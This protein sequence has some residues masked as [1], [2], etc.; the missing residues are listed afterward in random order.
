MK[1]ENKLNFN[2]LMDKQVSNTNRKSVDFDNKN[3]NETKINKNINK[4][5]IN[6]NK[7]I[8][9][10]M[11]IIS[12]K[13][14]S[15]TPIIN[16]NV[17]LVSQVNDKRNIDKNSRNMDNNT[18]ETT[19][20]KTILDTSNI[21]KIV[22][23]EEKICED[24]PD[25]EIMK[26]TDIENMI[27]YLII[28]GIITVEKI[29]KYIKTKN[30]PSIIINEEITKQTFTYEGLTYILEEEEIL[31]DITSII[32]ANNPLNRQPNSLF[33]DINSYLT[34]KMKLNVIPIIELELIEKS[35]LLSLI[36]RVLS[37]KL[38]HKMINNKKY[39]NKFN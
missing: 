27:N 10:S 23:I 30:I 13:T 6:R 32:N 4:K 38:N 8:E 17:K 26:E 21:N 9:N 19:S 25:E 24:I 15:N 34:K 14:I 39:T 29:K 20:I 3:I 37:L 7:H 16:K 31:Q 33:K 1:E 12:S 22:Q 28:P 18:W 2:Q 35:T 11:E 36:L 5:S